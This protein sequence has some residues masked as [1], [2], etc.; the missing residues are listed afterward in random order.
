MPAFAVLAAALVPAA[1][2]AARVANVPDASHDRG[3]VRVLGLDAQIWRGLDTAI[4]V[5]LGAVPVGTRAARAGLGGALVVAASGAV[6]YVVVRALLAACAE[7]R[8]LGALV[9]AVAAILPLVA[10]PWQSE[11]SSVG[12]SAT[13]ALLV[14]LPVALL[15]SRPAAPPSRDEGGEP[16]W[17]SAAF[18]LG[19]AFGYEP[20]VGACALAGA[21]VLTATREGARVSLVRQ[22][23]ARPDRV[24]AAFLAGLAPGLLGIVRVRSAGLSVLGSLAASWVGDP[25]GH[26]GVS[27]LP[28]AVAALGPSV[29]VL[30]AGGAALALLA[31]R[32]RPLAL[33]L[34]AIALLGVASGWLHVPCGPGRFSG[35][36]LA[37]LAAVCALAGAGMQALVR[38]VANA[39]VPLARASAAMVLLL[40]VVLP[41]DAAD[42]ALAR[43]STRGAA[44]AAWDDTA[45]GELP[46]STVVLLTTERAW[47]RAMA[48]RAR[49]SLRD[50]IVVLPGFAPGPGSRRELASDPALLPLWRDL[51][52]T[53]APS[54]ASLAALAAARPLEM[55]YEPRWGRALGA[56]L[57]ADGL[58]DRFELEPRG[59]SD[60]RSALAAFAPR[61][62]RLARLARGDGELAAQAAALLRARA[63]LLATVDSRDAEA[64]GKAVEDARAFED[65]AVA[66]RP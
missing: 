37:A 25:G 61:R 50:D 21:A 8:W 4:E 45:W 48:A 17:R 11:S 65:P 53:G 49:G 6:L 58:L 3:V 22:C 38:V 34:L 33:A 54:E 60:R 66:V 27:P 59:A 24:G 35:P 64:I 41:V 20:V 31:P 28:A 7:T 23:R 51:E 43:P 36:F 12:G 30:G 46:P 29:L 57:V 1:L 16:P 39:K 18:V 32:A 52:L 15:H 14:L 19:L 42:E 2:A 56:H 63:L 13:G 10:A 62:E 5:L 55:A 44:A 9:A 47:V 40:E 26:S